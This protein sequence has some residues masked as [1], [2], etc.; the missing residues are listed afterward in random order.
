MGVAFA[1]GFFI[2]LI[3]LLAV[4]AIGF[5]LFGLGVGGTITLT[6]IKKNGKPIKKPLFILSI[7]SLVVGILMMVPCATLSIAV[8]ID[9]MTPPE[10]FVETNLVIDQDGRQEQKFSVDGVEYQRINLDTINLRNVK[11]TPVFTW[12]TSGFLNK[13]NVGNYYEFENKSKF[14]FVLDEDNNI[15]CR[16]FDYVDINMFYHN[17][18]NYPISLSLDYINEEEKESLDLVNQNFEDE[19]LHILNRK[20]DG[21]FEITKPKNIYTLKVTGISYDGLCRYFEIIDI[22]SYNNNLYYVIDVNYKDLDN[23]IYYINDIP[24]E[25]E[26]YILSEIE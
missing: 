25:L 12:K 14:Y 2:I 19:I 11:K 22:V 15:F 9:C 18:D 7:V 10:N 16:S 23:P 26:S 3:I 1:L 17:I 8:Y 5:I 4:T 13:G 24:D 6:V 21:Y 20:D